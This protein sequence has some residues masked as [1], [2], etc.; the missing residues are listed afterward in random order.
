MLVGLDAEE[1]EKAKANGEV[2]L[3]E[4][5]IAGQERQAPSFLRLTGGRRTLNSTLAPIPGAG[6][7]HG[8]PVLAAKQ[9][10]EHAPSQR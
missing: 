3:K 10:R 5:R 4:R 8:V 7:R 9:P 1:D 2:S 6:E